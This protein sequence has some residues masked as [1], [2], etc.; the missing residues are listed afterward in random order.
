M[1][2]LAWPTAMLGMVGALLATRVGIVVTTGGNR[3]AS[4]TVLSAPAQICMCVWSVIMFWTSFQAECA[5]ARP[6]PATWLMQSGK[7]DPEFL[8]CST[9]G[10]RMPHCGTRS[11]RQSR[12][13]RTYPT[14]HAHTG[15]PPVAAASTAVCFKAATQGHNLC[16]WPSHESK[17]SAWR[18]GTACLAQA[19]REFPFEP[20]GVHMWHAATCGTL[21]MHQR[22]GRLQQAKC[23]VPACSQATPLARCT[24]TRLF[25]T[26]H[27]LLTKQSLPAE[28]RHGSR[29][30]R[31]SL[32]S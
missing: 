5:P 14:A 1:S 25:C 2:Q 32:A 16:R 19:R 28:G 18:V 12:Y 24:T 7:L 10:M 3:R 15:I 29:C 4:S 22:N 30:S 8:P 27:W 6:W 17:A 31:H 9:A 26:N 20:D 11:Q 21:R 13:F 23:P